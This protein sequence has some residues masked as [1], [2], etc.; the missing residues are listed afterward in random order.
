M[1]QHIFLI[2]AFQLIEKNHNKRGQGVNG[3]PKTDAGFTIKYMRGLG[4][5]LREPSIINILM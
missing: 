2:S 1:K 5:W 4:L 3:R